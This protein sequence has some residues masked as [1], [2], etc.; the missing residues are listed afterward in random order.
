MK[1]L[2]LP[3]LLILLL[4]LVSCS[5][6]FKAHSGGWTLE[7]ALEP[8]EKLVDIK[9]DGPGNDNLWYLVE[10][11]EED[12]IPRTKVFKEITSFSRPGG[13]IIIKERRY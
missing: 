4:F 13:K 12:Y 11:M 8:G 2:I 3:L 6:N 9:W 10:P 1:R 5:Q 7:L